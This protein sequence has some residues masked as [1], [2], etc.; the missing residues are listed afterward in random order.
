MLI[1]IEKNVGCL[2]KGKWRQIQASLYGF[3]LKYEL[4]LD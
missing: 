4:V 2:R 1:C 3:A